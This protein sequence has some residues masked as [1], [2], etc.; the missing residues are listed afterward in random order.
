MEI[1]FVGIAIVI[2]FYT[3]TVVMDIS[4]QHGVN[5]EKITVLEDGI[6]HLAEVIQN[7]TNNISSIGKEFNKLVDDYKERFYKEDEEIKEKGD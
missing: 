6:K 3:M 1:V 2:S 4:K 5:T 7:N